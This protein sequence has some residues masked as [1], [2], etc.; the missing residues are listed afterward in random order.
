M[1]KRKTYNIIVETRPSEKYTEQESKVRINKCL[2]I[3]INTYID[4]VKTGD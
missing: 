2:D 4:K 1:S 3:L